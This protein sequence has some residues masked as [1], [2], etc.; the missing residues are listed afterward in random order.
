MFLNLRKEKRE[1]LKNENNRYNN[2]NYGG[3]NFSICF[4]FFLILMNDNRLDTIEAK[5]DSF[6]IRQVA[7]SDGTYI[8]LKKEIKK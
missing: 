7:Y 2:R 1:E 4:E 5:I 8:N 3:H 6:E